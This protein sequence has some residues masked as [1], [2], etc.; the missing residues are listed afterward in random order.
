MAQN[1]HASV[2][3]KSQSLSFQRGDVRKWWNKREGNFYDE[4]RITAAAT[5]FWWPLNSSDISLWQFPVMKSD[6][7]CE[8]RIKWRVRL[9]NRKRDK[10]AVSDC[11]PMFW[12][13]SQLIRQMTA[14]SWHTCPDRCTITVMTARVQQYITCNILGL[15]SSQRAQK[16]L[17]T[18][19]IPRV[20]TLWQLYYPWMWESEW[21]AIFYFFPRVSPYAHKRAHASLRIS[22]WEQFCLGANRFCHRLLWIGN[23]LESESI[24]MSISIREQIV[25]AD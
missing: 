10:G 12:D 22:Y 5:F 25:A 3:K 8:R 9:S 7:K 20:K 6:E 2:Q 19:S 14:R 21:G 23:N 4:K 16:Q 1:C 15:L 17:T 13:R 18:E 24:W 11:D